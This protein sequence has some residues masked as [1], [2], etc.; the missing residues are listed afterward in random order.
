[1]LKCLGTLCVISAPSGTGKSTLIQALIQCNYFHNI[2][3]S[4]SYTT[5]IK[6]SEEIHGKDY[7]F[8]SIKEFKNMIH[9]NM[10][11]EYTKIFDHY[12]GT[13][14]NNILSMINDGIHIILDIDWHGAKQIRNKI[15]N[16]Y[17]I[18][19]LPP[20]KKELERR[21]TARK[22]DTAEVI[23]SR[24]E[25]VVDMMHHMTEYDYIIINDDFN[26]AFKHLKSIILSEQLRFLY[27]KTR[28]KH[29]INS[30][31]MLK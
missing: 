17:T 15:L 30:L 11:F 3:L 31:L 28:Y 16:N 27:Q 29:L 7:Y 23:S 24:M 8:I 9:N 2:K 6:R 19:I 12:Y 13:A 1:M 10:F 25:E 20:S 18:F 5:R 22:Q 14:K 26:I 21:L 4:I